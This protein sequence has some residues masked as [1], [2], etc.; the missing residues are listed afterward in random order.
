MS[1]GR[2]LNMK[3][4]RENPRRLLHWDRV[5][6]P[7]VTSAIAIGTAFG[8]GLLPLAPGTWGTIL[9][10]PLAY[11]TADWSTPARLA[12]WIGLAVIG[13]WACKTFDETMQTSD[14]QNLV[15]DEVVGLGITAWTAG[16]D[17]KWLLAAFVLFRL[18]DITKPPPVRQVDEWSKNRTKSDS[19]YKYWYSGFGVMADDIIAGFQGLICMVLLQH[20]FA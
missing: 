20:F 7:R 2:G 8:A 5:R 15:I 4:F 18:F 17:W 9:A 13:T 6:G 3:Y 10:V 14:N 19:Q 1:G 11:A 16:P 12:L